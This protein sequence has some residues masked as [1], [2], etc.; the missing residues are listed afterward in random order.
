MDDLIFPLVASA[1]ALAGGFLRSHQHVEAARRRI[2]GLR[3]AKEVQVDRLKHAAKT[4][5]MLKREYDR[6]VVRMQEI[7]EEI[8]EL[9]KKLIAARK[10]DRRVYVM[11]DRRTPNDLCWI[12]IVTNTHYAE[13]VH[14]Q[15][16]AAAQQ[17]WRQGRR[18]MIYALDANKAREKAVTRLPERLGYHIG[19][20]TQM[21]EDTPAP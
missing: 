17:S 7:Q 21:M 9:S 8:S 6:A 19:T 12:A 14:L 20:I 13:H 10:V 1:L 4:S 5:L 2:E 18:L 11:D 16:T 3:R 15:A